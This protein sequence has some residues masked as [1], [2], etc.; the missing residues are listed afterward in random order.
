MVSLNGKQKVYGKG[1]RGA[2]SNFLLDFLKE[3]MKIIFNRITFESF[4][5][6]PILDIAEYLYSRIDLLGIIEVKRLFSLN[7]TL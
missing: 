5:V 3:S 4:K 2:V 7:I 6:H 1:T